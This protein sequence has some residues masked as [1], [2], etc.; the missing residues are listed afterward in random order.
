MLDAKGRP[1][2]LW[3]EDTTLDVFRARLADPDPWVHAYGLIEPPSLL[4]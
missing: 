1:Y 2:F 4:R 3:D